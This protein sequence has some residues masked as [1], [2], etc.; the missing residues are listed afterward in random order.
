MR[1]ILT[2]SAALTLACNP[3]EGDDATATI[4][5]DFDPTVQ[6]NTDTAP[7]MRPCP[8]VDALGT[9]CDNGS[10]AFN[11]HICSGQNCVVA[12]NAAGEICT[13]QCGTLSPGDPCHI[14]IPYC[15][16]EMSSGQVVAGICVDIGDITTC[17]LP[18]VTATDCPYPDDMVCKPVAGFNS[19]VW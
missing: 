4:A 6:P 12:D 11:G 7:M 14:Q 8:G 19:C 15:E 3:T 9:P 16:D 2:L 10:T 1:S 5:S 17:M 13:L 18:C